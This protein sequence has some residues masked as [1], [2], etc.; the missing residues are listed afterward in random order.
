[1]W[2]KAIAEERV[3]LSKFPPACLPQTGEVFPLNTT[4]F[5]YGGCA[6]QVMIIW[7][8]WL[9]KFELNEW[10]IFSKAGE[11]LTI[12]TR[13]TSFKKPRCCFFHLKHANHFCWK[14]TKENLLSTTISLFDMFKVSLV[15]SDRC[16]S[17]Y[18]NDDIDEQFSLCAK[19]D[20]SATCEVCILRFWGIHNICMAK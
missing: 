16:R 11:R 18:S 3:D 5:V 2:I 19:G 1:M 15:E 14:E 8:S 20:H 13:Q 12:R 7:S 9:Y 17:R 4:A 6:L 10:N